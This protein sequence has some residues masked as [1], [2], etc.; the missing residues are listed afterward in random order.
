MTSR[1][2]LIIFVPFFL[3]AQSDLNGRIVDQQENGLPGATVIIS[4]T[5]KGSVT[6]TDGYFVFKSL[7]HDEYEL[8]ISSVGF[9]SKV[10]QVSHRGNRSKNIYCKLQEVTQELDMVVVEG[11]K[12]LTEKKKSGYNVSVISAENF[13]DLN[14]D[15]NQILGTL[16]GINL[17][18][19]GGLGSDVELSLNGMTGN[20]V[21]YFI[22]E[23]PMDFYG[24]SLTLNNYPANLIQAI[25]VYKGVTP[26]SL[27]S[28]A[29]GGTIN[30]TT[31][32][33]TDQF[34]DASYSYGSFNTHRASVFLQ[35][36]TKNNIHFR[37]MSFFNH[38][39]NDYLMKNTPKVDKFGNILGYG[40]ARRFHDAY[41]SGSV[42]LDIGV[43][44]RVFAD[45]FTVGLVYG[46]N[47]NE[48]QHPDVS[49]NRVFG[50]LTSE[51]RSL[52]AR[53]NHH[54]TWGKVTWKS[55]FV[56]GNDKDTFY[57]TLRRRYDW[58][59]NYKEI[60]TAENFSEPSIFELSDDRL[61]AR[62]AL[63]YDISN[64]HFLEGQY[65]KNYL[66]R[67]TQDLINERLNNA[68]NPSS[69]EKNFLGLSYNFISQD[70]S[71]KAVIFGKQYWYN[72]AI[73]TEEYVEKGTE[74]IKNKSSFSKTGY[75]MALSYSLSDNWLLKTSYE[76]AYRIPEAHEIM[77]D[78]LLI[79]PNPT[80]KPENS[81]NVNLGLIHERVFSNLSFKT[82]VNTFYRPVKNKIWRVPQGVLS[83][84][85]NIAETRIMGVETTNSVNVDNRYIFS[86]NMT[87][88]HHTDQRKYNE[89]LPN[90]NYNE[91]MPNDPYLFGDFGFQYRW[92]LD[93]V[94]LTTGINSRYVH[95]FFLYSESNG[96]TE[97]KRIIPTQFVNDINLNL[98]FGEGKYSTSLTVTNIFNEEAYDNW[99]LQKPGRA[100]NVKLRYFIN[101]Q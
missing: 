50:G 99:S 85:Q 98:V 7:P 88:Y 34:F 94:N 66:K 51:N 83:V 59:G 71:V 67:K 90:A 86:L 8:K 41:T 78:G 43:S 69:L 19:S 92:N 81:H 36:S 72:A 52:I 42:N 9:E 3:K 75:G 60:E 18:Q 79:L 91:R 14:L 89:G 17:R 61:W 49:I 35:H 20:Q 64:N 21:R 12:E 87:Y 39:D 93:K 84:N 26:V 11:N 24:S 6:D 77:G 15:V 70:Q 32:D 28:D 37:F 48:I 27:T 57:D 38:S 73:Y 58:E 1:I 22:D 97:N 23:V 5:E 76:L 4:G 74:V 13:Q 16:S 53:L 95:E 101:K 47:Q 29:L 63:K 62:T 31:P 30:I 10:I 55:N 100:I 80:L 44:D 45:G 25:E 46:A 82:E 40:E 96:S 56:I 2:L 54:K 65:S 68:G 33:I